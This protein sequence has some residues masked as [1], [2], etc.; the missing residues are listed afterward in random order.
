MAIKAFTA[1]SH[2]GIKN[3]L[4][5]PVRIHR[6]NDSASVE[7]TAIWDTGATGSAIT[8]STVVSLGL[9]QTGACMVS[10]ANGDVEQRTFTIDIG[11]PNGVLVQGIVATEVDALS[12]GCD[13]LIGMDIIT[14]GD[15]SV[16]NHNGNTC[17]SFRIPSSHEIDYVQSPDFGLVKV[18]S[19]PV[20][21]SKETFPNS[22]C[23]CGS[24]KKYKRCHGMR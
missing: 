8:K 11:L 18:S 13:S 23:P 15:F 10:T 9:A 14:L 24:G 2:D 20:S 19:E 12:G 7:I 4:L 5:T 6:P 22:P 16:T 17:F 1:K 21:S 3:V